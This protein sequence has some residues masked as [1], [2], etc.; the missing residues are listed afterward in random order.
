MSTTTVKMDSLHKLVHSL[1][2]SRPKVRDGP[3]RFTGH[4]RKAS[5]GI[6]L[7]CDIPKISDAK[8]IKIVRSS[9]LV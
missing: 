4:G 6:V 8:P 2:L 7:P 3:M 9:Q 5:P 1:S